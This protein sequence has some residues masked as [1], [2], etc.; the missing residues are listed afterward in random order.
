MGLMDKAM[1]AAQQQLV[2]RAAATSPPPAAAKSDC[3]QGGPH[4]VT[5]VNKGSINMRH[6]QSHLNDMH[7]RGYRLAHVLEQDGNTV[8]V[9]EHVHP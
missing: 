6:W 3:P 5:E 8:Q 2:Q 9:Y 7:D 1:E 4:Y